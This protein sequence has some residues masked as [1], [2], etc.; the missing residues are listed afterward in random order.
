MSILYHHYSADDL[1]MVSS[2]LIDVKE[3]GAIAV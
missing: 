1:A 2:R 3:S